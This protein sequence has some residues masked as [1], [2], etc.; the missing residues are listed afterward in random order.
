MEAQ[1]A[2]VK[3]TGFEGLKFLNEVTYPVSEW[4]QLRLIE[5]LVNH[6]PSELDN[7]SQWLKSEN[8][9]VVNFALRL[10]EIYRQYDLY[11]QV[12][13]CLSHP[14]RIICKSAVTTISQISNENTPDLL[15]AHYQ[16]YDAF[17]QIKILKILQADGTENQLPFLLSILN[18]RD[19][20]YKLEAVK[21]IVNISKT[22]VE[23][24]E[25]IVDKSL[26]P[27]NVILSQIKNAA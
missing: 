8:L 6:T 18:H 12:K 16:D 17:T 11:D 24:I 22:G 3:M 7:I 1:I 5:E 20:S 21:A 13:S 15:I 27:W 4:Q 9:T 26:F 23:E 2:I 19:D 10:I 14:S 25:K